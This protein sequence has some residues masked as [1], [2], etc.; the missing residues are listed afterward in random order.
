MRNAVSLGGDAGTLAY[1]AGA[2]V[3]A[4]ERAYPP[5]RIGGG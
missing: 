4:F 1:I 5:L 2:V 3:E